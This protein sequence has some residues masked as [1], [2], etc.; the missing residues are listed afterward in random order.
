MRRPAGVLCLAGPKPG[1]CDVV[2]LAPSGMEEAW[3]RSVWS[4]SGHQHLGR[5]F[6]AESQ[7]RPLDREA[8]TVRAPDSG[9]IVQRSSFQVAISLLSLSVARV[10]SLAT[11]DPPPY[12]TDF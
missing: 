2:P 3:I 12:R 4:A 8:A 9:G 7:E 10:A 1:R 11:Y 6:A 5:S